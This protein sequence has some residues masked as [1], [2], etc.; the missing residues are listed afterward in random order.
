MTIGSYPGIAWAGAAF[1]RLSGLAF[2]QGGMPPPGCAGVE[3]DLRAILCDDPDGRSRR[4]LQAARWLALENALR[5]ISLTLG[6][7]GM[8]AW[9]YKGSDFA[10]TLYPDPALRPMADLDLIVRRRDL[11]DAACSL[12]GDGWEPF[13]PGRPLLTSGVV[14]GL[15]LMKDGIPLDLHSHPS[16][17]PST[18]PG[19]LPHPSETAS[20]ATPVGLLSCPDDYRL[21]LTL[22]HMLRHGFA[23]SIWWVDA[24]LLASRMGDGD[25]RRFTRLAMGTG[26]ARRLAPVAG[27]LG[28]FRG[29][30]V[31]ARVVEMM[32]ASG[33]DRGWFLDAAGDRR[34][35]GSIAALLTLR[36]WRKASFLSVVLLRLAAG[37]PP[38]RPSG[39]ARV[40]EG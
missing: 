19:L 7:S 27:M 20:I 22:L 40:I 15:L 32:A 24:A 28:G 9:A 10:L 17:F 5:R 11:L 26:L 34:G 8:E 12:E 4:R 38:R 1:A 33:T 39:K 29:V 3:R 35:S 25:W 18:L 14:S 37:T 31:P 23:R 13:S 36:G 21:L 30:E 16:Y 6:R 2:D